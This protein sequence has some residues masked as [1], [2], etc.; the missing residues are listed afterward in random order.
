VKYGRG[1]AIVLLFV[2]VAVAHAL[3]HLPEPALMAVAGRLCHVERGLLLIVRRLRSVDRRLPLL[4]A[5]A[6]VPA[7]ARRGARLVQRGVLGVDRL[8]LDVESPLG[9][10]GRR[11]LAVGE[12]LL[13]VAR[14]LLAPNVLARLDAQP[15]DVVF[16]HDDAPFT[17]SRTGPKAPTAEPRA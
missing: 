7:A 12:P 6:V 9:A 11:L 3:E 5:Q 2:L 8:L 16:G 4:D 1:D 10:V 17:T 15:L 14:D 13:E